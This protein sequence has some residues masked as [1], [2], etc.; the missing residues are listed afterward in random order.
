MFLIDAAITLFGKI[1]YLFNASINRS[2]LDE[3]KELD[4]SAYFSEICQRLADLLYCIDT[5]TMEDGNDR[6]DVHLIVW[7]I[8]YL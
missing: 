8:L 2:S 6:N 4:F 7:S 1:E 3:S 5:K